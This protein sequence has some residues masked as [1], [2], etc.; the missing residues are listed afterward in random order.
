MQGEGKHW[1]TDACKKTHTHA[2]TWHTNTRRHHPEV[3]HDWEV[4]KE[5]QR[6]VKVKGETS[7]GQRLRRDI[8]TPGS[9]V[10]V[11]LCVQEC[12]FIVFVLHYFY[13][14]LRL[15]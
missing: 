9:G 8:S 12:V 6:S 1:N 2:H 11:C 5:A 3:V 14:Q 10:C 7:R 4:I 15:C 13:I